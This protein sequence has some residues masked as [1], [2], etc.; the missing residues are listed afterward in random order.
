MNNSAR[1]DH[2]EHRLVSR[3]VDILKEYKELAGIVIFVGGAIFWAFAYFATKQQLDEA[4][5][6]TDENIGVINARLESSNLSDV[7]HK[8]LEETVALQKKPDRTQADEVT[9]QQL[10]TAR[11]TIATKIAQADN[12]VA[13]ATNRLTS[14]KC[15]TR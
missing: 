1:T 4:R 5:C 15:V 11:S 7:L 12:R 3:V 14:G 10:Q 6:I 9:L 13:E 2:S 8:N